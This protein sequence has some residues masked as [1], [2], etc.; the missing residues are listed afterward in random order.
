MEKSAV[1]PKAK[2]KFNL[3]GLTASEVEGLKR[4]LLA[5][6]AKRPNGCWEWL[7]QTNHG[8]YGKW[9]WK[10][11]PLRIHRLAWML[12]RGEIPDKMLVCHR[13]DNPPCWN[14]HHLFLGTPADNMADMY[15]KKRAPVGAQRSQAKLTEANVLEIRKARNSPD[16][17]ANQLMQK[18]G[19][20]RAVLYD[21]AAGRRWKHLKG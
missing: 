2:G 15:A 7:G 12:Y 21:V 8:G 17:N 5:K 3:A 13:C 10:S 14:P 4:R 16:W 19:I 18:F 11:Y 20:G 6:T 1:K 9:E